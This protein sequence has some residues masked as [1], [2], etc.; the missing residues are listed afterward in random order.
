MIAMVSSFRATPGSRVE[1]YAEICE[2]LLERWRKPE[3]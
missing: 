1:L 3:A 2:V